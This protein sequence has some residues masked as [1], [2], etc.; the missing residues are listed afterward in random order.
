MESH[1]GDYCPNKACPDYDEHSRLE[2]V[3]ISQ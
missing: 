3:K 1:H 2:G